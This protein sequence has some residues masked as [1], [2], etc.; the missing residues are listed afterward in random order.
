M[1]ALTGPPKGA[2]AAVVPTTGASRS[3]TTAMPQAESA[4][5][6][7]TT[8]SNSIPTIVPTLKPKPVPSMPG[9]G[10]KVVRFLQDTTSKKEDEGEVEVSAPTTP[11]EDDEDSPDSEGSFTTLADVRT[12]QKAVE[13]DVDD[14]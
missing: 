6:N 1:Q 8:V 14:N 13:E 3:A 7:P 11:Q 5:F 10:N 4:T 2:S 12:D 9:A